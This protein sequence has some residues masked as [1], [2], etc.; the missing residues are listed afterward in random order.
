M[1]K[2]NLILIMITI[3]LQFSFISCLYSAIEIED[4]LTTIDLNVNQNSNNFLQRNEE[5]L[6]TIFGTLL[7]AIISVLLAQ[8]CINKRYSVK[9]I[10]EY[11]ALLNNLVF[12]LNWQKSKIKETRT[13]LIEAVR[14]YEEQKE[15]I[16]DLSKASLDYNFLDFSRNN[17]LKFFNGSQEIL[18]FLTYYVNQVKHINSSLNLNFLI[19]Y[20]KNFDE[21]D[22]DQAIKT[23]FSNLLN[24]VVILNKIVEHLD[25]SLLKEINNAPKKCKP[26]LF[27]IPKEITE[28]LK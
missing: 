19:D 24:D 17:L 9:K 2:T 8:F 7:V 25:L 23:I 18:P 26:I 16:Y 1:K 10:K 22:F 28:S 6:L 15:V 5:T 14:I 11:F 12:E 20:K 27:S 21:K 3:I 13:V 4:S